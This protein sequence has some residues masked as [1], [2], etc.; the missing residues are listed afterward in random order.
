MVVDFE[1]MS[2]AFVIAA[3]YHPRGEVFGQA[4]DNGSDGLFREP[5]LK[6]ASND[7]TEFSQRFLYSFYV[8]RIQWRLAVPSG[9]HRV[10][11]AT[12]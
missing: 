7:D 4:F 12:Q 5:T 11:S 10:C 9:S 1:D 8:F 3:F 6:L 2:Q